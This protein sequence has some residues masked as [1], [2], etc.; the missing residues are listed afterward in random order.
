MSQ[1][2]GTLPW[3]A[4]TTK[5]NL[6]KATSAALQA[7]G[8]ETFLPLYHVRCRWSDRIKE[9]DLPLFAGYTFSRFEPARRVPVLSTPGA[10]S[11]VGFGNCP[12]AIA[13]SEIAAVRRIIASGLPAEPWPFLKLGAR[14]LIEYGPLEGLEGIILSLKKQSRLVVSVSMLQR[15]VAVEID[16]AWARRIR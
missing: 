16:R 14:V 6:E 5:P 2:N 4:I 7:R 11:I 12:A 9:L 15:L 13:E 1:S 8:L 3:F 10:L